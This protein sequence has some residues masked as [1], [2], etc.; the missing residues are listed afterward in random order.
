[1]KYINLNVRMYCVVSSDLN[2]YT[3]TSIVGSNKKGTDT[4]FSRHAPKIL[5]QHILRKFGNVSHNFLI[6][7]CCFT[8]KA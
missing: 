8:I 5:L 7:E 6:I 1:M 2:S 4:I 3:Y